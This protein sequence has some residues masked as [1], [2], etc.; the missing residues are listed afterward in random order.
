[1]VMVMVVV[2]MNDNH[3]LRL[4]RVGY[5]EAEEENQSEQNLFHALVW[6][7]SFLNTELL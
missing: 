7:A 4:R 2:R 3:Y 6:R 5:C 1:M